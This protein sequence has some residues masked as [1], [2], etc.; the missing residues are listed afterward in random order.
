MV[1]IS[2]S[3]F[4]PYNAADIV[5]NPAAY[6]DKAFSI[7]N[8]DTA[9]KIYIYTPLLLKITTS[10]L[11]CCRHSVQPGSITCSSIFQGIRIQHRTFC[12]KPLIATIYWRQEILTTCWKILLIFTSL[13]PLLLLSRQ[14]LVSECFTFGNWIRNPK[15]P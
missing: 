11:N 3:S 2:A 6:H 10:S 1:K 13:L 14:Q 12:R 9:P 8:L 7:K 5:W 15:F 4:F